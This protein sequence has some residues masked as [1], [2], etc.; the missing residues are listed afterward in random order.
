MGTSSSL[1]STALRSV[2]SGDTPLDMF[3]MNDVFD[4]RQPGYKYHASA[5]SFQLQDRYI[6]IILNPHL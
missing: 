6:D 3:S 5:T 4:T 1:S 2:E